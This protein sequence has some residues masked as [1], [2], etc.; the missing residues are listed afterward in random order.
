VEHNTILVRNMRVDNP[1]F[2]QRVLK[3]EEAF[4]L[5]PAKELLRSTA[6]QLAIA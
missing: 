5:G 6:A 1:A 2:L 4:F 3:T